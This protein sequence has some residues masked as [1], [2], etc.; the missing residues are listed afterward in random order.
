MTTQKPNKP[1]TAPGKKPA[2]KTEGR[3]GG[4]PAKTPRVKTKGAKATAA[5]GGWPA[6]RNGKPAGKPGEKPA[7]APSS[8][9][10]PATNGERLNRFLARSGLCSRREAD[11]MIAEGRIRINGEKIEDMGR[12]V[13]PSDL[14]LADGKPVSMLA[15]HTYLLYNKP[16]GQLCTRRDEKGRDLIYKHVEVGPNVQSVGRL[17]MDSEGLLLLTDD[18]EL[19]NLMTRPGSGVAREYRVR[20]AGNLSLDS[21]ESLRKGGLDI[22]E[23]EKSDPWEIVVDSE[24]GG[25]CWL[26]VV[27]RRGRNREVRRTLEAAGHVVRRLIRTRFGPL[28]LEDGVRKSTSRHLTTGE[29]KQL[30]RSVGLGEKSA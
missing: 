29:V 11:K 12:R 7:V 5:R 17:D 27:I 20:V 13:Q 14:V 30:R 26:T 24:T 28:T 9:S 19:A 18:G 2:R 8:P 15:E 3:S 16:P 6:A 4:K 1:K 10:T 21:L 25:H 23:G 22:G